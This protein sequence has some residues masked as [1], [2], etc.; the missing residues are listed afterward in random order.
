VTKPRKS[1]HLGFKRW[2]IVAVIVLEI[3]V[4]GIY[5]PISPH[6]QLAPETLTPVVELPIIGNFALTNTMVSVFIADIILILAAIAVFRAYRKP[7]SI[8]KGVAGVFEMIIEALYNLAQTTAGKWAKKIFPVM[9]TIF[10]LVLMVNLMK[11]IPGVES[12]GWLHEVPE[13]QHGYPVQSLGFMAYIYDP[14]EEQSADNGQVDVTHEKRSGEANLAEG[15]DDEHGG[16]Y[17]IIPF[18]R[19]ASTDLSFTL[20]L[21]VIAILGVQIIGVRAGGLG[22]FT[23]FF[24]FGNFLKMWTKKKI[25]AFDMIMPLIDI[26]VGMLE[27][28]AE[29]ARIIS[30]A[31]RLLGVMFAGAILLF[32]MGSLFLVLQ[33][34]FLALELFF[35]V[36]QAFVFA[37]LTLV[38]MTMA[39]HS[40]SGGHD[41]EHAE[42][43]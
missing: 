9:A 5:K 8:P 20:S 30:F 12:V 31:F 19:P 33:S 42:A 3:I 25:G 37:M 29:V 2:I 24:N 43:H 27:L 11:L 10:L 1:F 28:M 22:Y 18:V 41:E 7:G 40:H 21:A 34:G 23:K 35:G 26:F 17:N 32:L 6:V 14:G 15:G 38:F 16:G 4:A 39:T 13:G 36:I